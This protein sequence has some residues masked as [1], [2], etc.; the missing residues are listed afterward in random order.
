VLGLREQ[1][2]S[3]AAIAGALNLSRLEPTAERKRIWALP[4]LAGRLEI[5]AR[6][7]LVEQ[8]THPSGTGTVPV[9]RADRT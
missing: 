8:S 9:R 4:E 5:L 6:A 1:G 3:I 7:G 2:S